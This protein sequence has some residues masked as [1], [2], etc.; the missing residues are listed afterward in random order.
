MCVRAVRTVRLTPIIVGLIAGRAHRVALLLIWVV[1]V[2]AGA[3]IGLS[4][5]VRTAED[6][7]WECDVIYTWRAV[8]WRLRIWRELLP[9]DRRVGIG[10]RSMVGR[11]GAR[12]GRVCTLWLR[13]MLR[14]GDDF[15]KDCSQVNRGRLTKTWRGQ[16]TCESSALRSALACC[17]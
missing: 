13:V 15:H 12:K 5:V 8:R 6:L 2:V 7:I 16:A 10:G 9:F 14:H 4:I 1:G 17:K 11:V 3:A